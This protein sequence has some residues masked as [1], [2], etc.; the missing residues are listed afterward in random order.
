VGNK[1]RPRLIM[2]PAS[3]FKTIELGLSPASDDVI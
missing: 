1:A 3:S 2:L